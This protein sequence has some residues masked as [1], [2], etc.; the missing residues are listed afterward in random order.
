MWNMKAK[1]LPLVI[2]AT[3]KHK[4]EGFRIQAGS[5]LM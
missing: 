5:G 2:G 3:E 1:V 4:I